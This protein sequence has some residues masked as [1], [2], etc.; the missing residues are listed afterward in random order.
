[1]LNR[2]LTLTALL[3][4]F[5]SQAQDE[6]T[7]ITLHLDSTTLSLVL[8]EISDQTGISFSYINEQ[9]PLNKIVSIH[10]DKSNVDDVMSKFFRSVDLEFEKIGNQIVLKPGRKEEIPTN[11]LIS[12]TIVDGPNGSPLEFASIALA[13]KPIGT[14]SNEDGRFDFYVPIENS[15]DSIIISML[16]YGRFKSTVS[17]LSDIQNLI[18]ELQVKPVMLK[19]VIVTDQPLTGTEI[20]L[21]AMEL[22][23]ENFPQHP[24]LAKGFFRETY[25][26]NDRTVFLVDAAVDISDRGYKLIKRNRKK[27]HEKVRLRNVR[28]SLGQFQSAYRY[29]FLDFNFLT[30]ALSENI[31]KYRSPKVLDKW[32]DYDFTLDTI[33][34]EGLD[35]Y[36]V[37]SNQVETPES[38]S[39]DVYYVHA[40]TFAIKRRVYSDFAKG[41]NNLYEWTINSTPNFEY[42]VK[43]RSV[44]Y[45]FEEYDGEM[46]PKYIAGEFLAD[47]YDNDQN[48]VE[49]E[50]KTNETLIITDLEI[51]K[52]KV[53]IT[54]RMDPSI[55]LNLQ[56]TNYDA[57]FWDDKDQ[58]KL[59]PLTM[60]QLKDLESEIDLESQFRQNAV[61]S[62]EFKFFSK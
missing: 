2:I 45:E 13:S 34:F 38:F 46:Y 7:K 16:G 33:L 17:E 28:A 32:K 31:I 15:Q 58:I 6:Q 1:M 61:L 8:S 40:E 24:F 49:W 55:S 11:L 48:T 27:L 18:I 12:G 30:Y 35:P 4:S 21:K 26:E 29:S 50:L 23:V 36:Y 9:I 20:I 25:E 54:E 53:K 5:T 37:V 60:Q 10:V 3:L 39:K 59:V 41:V 19:Q 52:E 22:V 62:E 43:E 57:N 51:K 42:Q 44:I 14:V 47:I 56:L